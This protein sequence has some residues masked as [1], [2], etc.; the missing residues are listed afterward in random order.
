MFVVL[1]FLLYYANVRLL[2]IIIIISFLDCRMH[3]HLELCAMLNVKLDS[4]RDQGVD[5]VVLLQ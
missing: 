1:L 2:S 3:A 4:P 5:S